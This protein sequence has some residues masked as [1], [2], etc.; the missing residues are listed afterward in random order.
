MTSN[1]VIP[2]T[3]WIDPNEGVILYSERILPGPLYKGLHRYQVIR[4]IRNDAPADYKH[5]LGLASHFVGGGVEIPGGQWNYR[6]GKGETWDTV[7]NL[8][9]MGEKLR[10]RTP[11]ETEAL[12]AGSGY[13]YTEGTAAEWQDE[14][15]KEADR[16]KM[17]A[18]K[19]G[20]NG[21]HFSI[22]R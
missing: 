22:T 7:A 6:T 10:H 13:E 18:S 17:A 12:L 14:Y 11:A 15:L 21:T 8:E 1:R 4:V 5:D 16:R 2:S 9:S 3:D 19:K 20:V